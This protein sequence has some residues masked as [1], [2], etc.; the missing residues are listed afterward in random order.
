MAL[1]ELCETADVECTKLVACVDRH[2]PNEQLV[3]LTRD[4]GWVGFEPY[5]LVDWTE[6]DDI[7]SDS[8]LFLSMDV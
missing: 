7:L 4:L 2:A 5:T 8:W 6:S 1:L 3:T